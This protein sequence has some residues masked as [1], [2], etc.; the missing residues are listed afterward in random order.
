MSEQWKAVP[1]KPGAE[2]V[3]APTYRICIS[4][5]I[6]AL[7][8]VTSQSGVEG[9]RIHPRDDSRREKQANCSENQ[10]GSVVTLSIT[11]FIARE[12]ANV[13]QNIHVNPK[14]LKKRTTLKTVQ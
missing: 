14:A 8:V 12:H 9:E 7:K 10:Q 5:A 3:Q 4:A 6:G 2:A 11:G 1:L 13:K